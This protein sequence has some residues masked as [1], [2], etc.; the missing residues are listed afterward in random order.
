MSKSR[1]ARKGS[2]SRSK[3]WKGPNQS[4]RFEKADWNGHVR[5]DGKR[6]VRELS[7]ALF[8]ERL[9]PDGWTLRFERVVE[10]VVA[11]KRPWLD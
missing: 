1:K 7:C 10:A 8:A 6:F 9:I 11:G 2:V 5:R 4:T 3:P